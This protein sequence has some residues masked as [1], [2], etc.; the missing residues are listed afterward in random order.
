[1]F[2]RIV[3]HQTFTPAHFLHPQY[4][5]STVVPEDIYI[6]YLVLSTI[7]DVML[8][9]SPCSTETVRCTGII[10]FFKRCNS[11]EIEGQDTKYL[12]LIVEAMLHISYPVSRVQWWQ[13]SCVQ[14]ADT[15]EHDATTHQH[16]LLINYWITFQDLVLGMLHYLM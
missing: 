11:V 4:L 12:I 10:S 1:M 3:L 2:V 8:D 15:G 9:I 5:S 14:S 7:D 6:F 16:F 13:Q